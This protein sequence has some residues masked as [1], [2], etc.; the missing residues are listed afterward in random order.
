MKIEHV[1]VRVVAPPV[2]RHTWAHD[3]P[4][5][6][7]TKTLVTIQTDAGVEGMGSTTTFTGH[8]FDRAVA[9][10]LRTLIP[11]L[12]GADPRARETLWQQLR[13]RT[14]PVAW[15][16]R[17]AI[18]IALWDI[19]GKVAGLPLYQL[20]GG[21][22][23]R[24]LSYAS[25]TLLK[26]VPTYLK[27]VDE[28][29]EQGFRAVKFHAW[30]LPEKDLELCRAVRRH[31]PARD[32]DFMFDA[33]GN[34]DLGGALRVAQE[35]EELGFGWFEAPLPDTDLAGYRA[36]TAR[37]KIPIVPAGNW[38]LDLPL[39][40][41]ALATRTWGA[42]R[43]DVGSCGGI[44]P[45][46]KIMALAEAAGLNCEVQCWAFTL[47][48]AANLHLICA[49]PNCTYFEQ[50]VPYDAFEYGAKDVIR[51]QPDGYVYALKGPGLGVELD[52]AAIDTA[53][54]LKFDCCNEN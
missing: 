13:P 1:T 37:V 38:V 19:L 48:Q 21:A 25:T 43:I 10:T 16:A 5:Q 4:E 24:I 34:Y 6:Y 26:D 27:F 17:A 8:D 39:V 11:V 33:E 20:L 30:G 18:D 45:A 32:V 3:L 52:W 47:Q 36:L 29:I 23:E 9:E 15:G 53:T 41:E 50:P 49:L 46:R 2:V 14:L 7:M 44:T 31:H 42:A 51:T 22:R 12:I 40:A 54:I 35:L 28:L